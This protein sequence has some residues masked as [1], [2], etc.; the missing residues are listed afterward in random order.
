MINFSFAVTHR[1]T[2][3]CCGGFGG[4]D[5]WMTGGITNKSRIYRKRTGKKKERERLEPE[6]VMKMKGNE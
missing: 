6:W 5:T 1:I 2:P 3:Y 4:C